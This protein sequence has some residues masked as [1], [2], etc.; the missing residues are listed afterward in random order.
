MPELTGYVG[1]SRASIYAMMARGEFV[2]PIK[3]GERA[4]G[5]RSADIDAWLAARPM[6]AA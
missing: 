6:A 2:R 4:V 3:L 1:L 5:W